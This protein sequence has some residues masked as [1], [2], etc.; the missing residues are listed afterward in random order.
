MLL[1]SKRWRERE[2]E[3]ERN[4]LISFSYKRACV[5]RVVGAFAPDREVVCTQKERE[6]ERKSNN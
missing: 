5:S 3:R 1:A 2:R 6:R 4:Y